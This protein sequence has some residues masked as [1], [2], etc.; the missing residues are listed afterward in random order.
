MWQRV[1]VQQLE[2]GLGHLP[3]QLPL[4]LLLKCWGQQVRMLLLQLLVERLRVQ[5]LRHLSASPPAPPPSHL[6]LLRQG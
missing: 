2:Q 3:L 5:V 1:Q 6:P 4:V